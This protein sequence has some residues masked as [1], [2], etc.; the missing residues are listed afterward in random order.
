MGLLTRLNLPKVFMTQLQYVTKMTETEGPP[1]STVVQ[2]GGGG[3]PN[4]TIYLSTNQA[5][6]PIDFSILCLSFLHASTQ[7]SVPLLVP[8]DDHDGLPLLPQS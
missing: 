1:Q 5:V 2:E 8:Q 6:M 7:L 3:T 4:N